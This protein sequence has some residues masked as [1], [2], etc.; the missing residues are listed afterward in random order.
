MGSTCPTRTLTTPAIGRFRT[1]NIPTFRGRNVLRAVED[2]NRRTRRLVL[3][4]HFVTN[5]RVHRRSGFANPIHPNFLGRKKRSK[6]GRRTNGTFALSN[7][8]LTRFVRH[9]IHVS[10]VNYKVVGTLVLNLRSRRVTR[11]LMNTPRRPRWGELFLLPTFLPPFR[12]PI[13]FPHLFRDR[14][15]RQLTTI[16]LTTR[17]LF[18]PRTL[19]TGRF[20]GRCVMPTRRLVRPIMVFQFHRVGDAGRD[21][22]RPVIVSVND[23]KDKR[24]LPI[25]LEEVGGSMP[26]K[27]PTVFHLLHV[28]GVHDQCEEAPP[29]SDR[30]AVRRFRCTRAAKRRVGDGP[31]GGA[32]FLSKVRE[33]RRRKFP[34]CSGDQ[35]HGAPSLFRQGPTGRGSHAQGQVQRVGGPVLGTEQGRSTQ[36]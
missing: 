14:P 5:R 15:P 24:T 6:F 19:S 36:P 18:P 7:L 17:F 27:V 21:C 1:L 2:V 23:C 35:G 16:C 34:P 3:R 9:R 8:H 12:C 28:K 13:P 10:R 20:G 11:L 22:F 4:P 29:G 26:P 25:K 30:G 31:G 32:T 33:Q